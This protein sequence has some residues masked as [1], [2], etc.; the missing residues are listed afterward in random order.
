MGYVLTTNDTHA[1]LVRCSD[2]EGLFADPPTPPREE[3]V[4]Y[5]CAPLDALRDAVSAPAGTRVGDLWIMISLK[6]DRAYD[7]TYDL[8]DVVILQQRPSPDAPGLVDLIVEAGVRPPEWDFGDLSA[9]RQEQLHFELFGPDTAD[10]ANA[11]DADASYGSCAAIPRLFARRP[12]RRWGEL[13]LVGCEPDAPLLAPERTGYVGTR[14]LALDRTGRVMAE[15][16]L[17]LCVR[18]AEPSTLGGDLCDVTVDARVRDRPPAAFESVWRLWRDDRA[19]APNEWA[20]LTGN[21]RREWLQLTRKTAGADVR[22][23]EY[24]L[25]GRFVTDAQGLHCAIGE[26]VNGPGGYY[27]QCWHSLGDCLDGGFGAVPPF[28]L[29]WHDYDVAHRALTGDRLSNDTPY[30]Q[31]V[32]ER[33]ESWGVTVVRQ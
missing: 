32:V 31:A 24:H 17:G 1:P 23:G 12:D 21:L 15:R 18:G 4:L 10:R 13:R 22:G 3:L 14:L 11:A 20:P 16:G 30:L 25:D 2:V 33:L 19:A 6:G 28:T 26:A 5:E 8:V 27:G 29:V 7:W 9:S